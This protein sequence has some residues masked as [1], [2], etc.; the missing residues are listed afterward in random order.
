MKVGKIP[1]KSDKIRVKNIS[2]RV[3]FLNFKHAYFKNNLKTFL[4]GE[5]YQ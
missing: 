3:G 4:V 2:F 5:F 1:S